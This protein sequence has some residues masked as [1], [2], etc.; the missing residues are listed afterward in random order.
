MFDE[1]R[2]NRGRGLLVHAGPM[3]DMGDLKTG[4][5]CLPYASDLSV[6][7]L[8]VEAR[9]DM[10]V[11]EDAIAFALPDI[12]GLSISRVDPS[13]DRPA[14]LASYV[15]RER[16]ARFSLHWGPMPLLSAERISSY[17]A[18]PAE[19]SVATGAVGPPGKTG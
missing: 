5:A 7:L 13:G 18:G 8:A 14:Q 17:P 15:C 1:C 6:E 10:D 2:L 12:A 3:N 11:G 19:H 16:L 9:L 4:Q